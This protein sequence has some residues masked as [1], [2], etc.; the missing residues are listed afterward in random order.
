ML[1]QI[2]SQTLQ[3]LLSYSNDH[4]K[5]LGS[6]ILGTV[7]PGDVV[8]IQGGPS[9]GKT[10]LLY[11]VI[12]TCLLPRNAAGGGWNKV[13]LIY[14]M[15]GRF[16]IPRLRDILLHRLQCLPQPIIQ[17]ILGKCLENIH[18]FKPTSTEHLTLSLASVSLYHATRFP[19]SEIGLVGIHSVDAYYWSDRFKGEQLHSIS[20]AAIIPTPYHALGDVIHDTRTTRGYTVV[21][22]HWG[23]IHGNSN[24]LI[25][26]SNI[27]RAPNSQNALQQFL[28]PHLCR[29][30]ITRHVNLGQSDGRGIK[31]IIYQA[32]NSVKKFN[33][34]ITNEGIVLQQNS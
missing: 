28:P 23:L 8:H 11:Y 20:P 21:L 26:T 13:V 3:Q 25:D 12:A 2:H 32:D 14:D 16:C 29:L 9:T 33:M 19:D 17:G 5:S 7:C 34:N 27:P 1:Q 10:H 18:V 4:S 31:G 6:S 22:T 24:M 30:P 15:D